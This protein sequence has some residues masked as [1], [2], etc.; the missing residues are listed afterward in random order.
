MNNFKLLKIACYT[1]NLSMSII[2]NL[3]PLLFL[4]F[5]T[6]YDVSYSLLGT[7]VLIN[8]FTQLLVDLAFSF[9]SHK[10]NITLSV[11]I[12]PVLGALGLIIFALAPIVFSDAIYLGL[13]IGTVIFSAASG[14]AEVL[15]SPLIAEIPAE[16]PDHEMS[17]LHSVYAWGVVGVVI[18]TTLFLHVFDN[19]SW[20]ILAFVFAI[21]PLTA[22]VL[23]AFSDIPEMK[24]PNQTSGALAFMKNS[25]VWLCVFEIFLGGAIECTM[26]QWASGYLEQALGISKVWGDVFGVALFAAALGL[27]RTLYTRFGK[28]PTRVVLLGAIGAAICYAVAIFSPIPV[29]GLLACGLTGF[30]ASMLW[31]GNIIISSEKYPEGGVIMYALMASGGDLGASVG[32]QLVGVVTDIVS[33]SPT[34]QSFAQTLSTTADVIGMRAGMLIGLLFALAA[35]PLYAAFHRSS[36]VNI[37]VKEKK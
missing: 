2:S 6:L 8:F 15:M 9:F 31:P 24:T 1:T 28:F 23:F 34:M 10:F 32:P 36:K 21:I 30:C 25:G 3:S 12:M 33:E 37:S 19:N 16:N 17:K 11:K 35:I 27:G 13:V 7:L 14:L 4:T 22:A 26:A 18:V 5:K 29:I 20:Q